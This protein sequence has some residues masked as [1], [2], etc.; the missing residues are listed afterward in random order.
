M[1]RLHPP[2]RDGQAFAGA[3]QAPGSD[4]SDLRSCSDLGSVTLTSGK[5]LFQELDRL[6][7]GVSVRAAPFAGL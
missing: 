4:A 2:R 6:F 3:L 7:Y 1:P 5:L